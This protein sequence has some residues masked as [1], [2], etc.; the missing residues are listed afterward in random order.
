[1]NHTIYKSSSTVLEEC[2]VTIGQSGN[3]LYVVNELLDVSVCGVCMG[4]CGY[5]GYKLSICA[6][7][8]QT[9]YS[10]IEDTS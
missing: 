3:V 6:D 9:M 10:P 4:T 2:S 8:A 1:M 5:R 7:G